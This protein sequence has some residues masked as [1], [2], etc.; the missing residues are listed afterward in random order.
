MRTFIRRKSKRANYTYELQKNT[1]LKPALY[2]PQ[3][4]KMYLLH[5]WAALAKDFKEI[6]T[7]EL[8]KGGIGDGKPDSAF[9]QKQ[10]LAGIKVE[11]EHTNNPLIAKEISKDHLTEFPDYYEELEKMEQKLKRKK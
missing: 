8:I 1:S 2:S 4:G 11:M 5:S 9:D 7:K 6:K 3:T 10:L